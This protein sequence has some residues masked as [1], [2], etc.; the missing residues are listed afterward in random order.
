MKR[1]KVAALAMAA[2]RGEASSFSGVSVNLKNTA[3]TDGY[4]VKDNTVKLDVGG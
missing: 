3:K 2:L 4:E 1:R